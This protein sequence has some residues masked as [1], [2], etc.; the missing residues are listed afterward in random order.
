VRGCAS[1]HYVMTT[2]V[3]STSSNFLFTRDSSFTPTADPTETICVD[4]YDEVT[5]VRMTAGAKEWGGEGK[6]LGFADSQ[7]THQQKQVSSIVLDSL[8]SCCCLVDIPP[9]YE[10]DS[11]GQCSVAQYNLTDICV[12]CCSMIDW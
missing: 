1:V 3:F 7:S 12:A 10:L 8:N 9:K 4:S 11:L 2:L 5:Q 6:C